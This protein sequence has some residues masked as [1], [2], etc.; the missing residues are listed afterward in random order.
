[1]GD[2]ELGPCRVYF[3]EEGSESDVGR[4][5]GGVTVSFNTDLADLMSDQFGTSPEDQVITGQGATVT[6]PLAEYT[7]KNLAFALNQTVKTTGGKQG[8]EGS[9][10][11]GT[12][13]TDKAK[14]LLIK[15]YVGGEISTDTEDWIRFPLAA[16]TGT[17]DISFD[18]STQ[19]IIEVTFTAFPNSDDV[20][21]IL[22]DETAAESG[23]SS[24][25]MSSSSASSSSASSSS[26]S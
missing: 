19:R 20:L 3:G 18:G 22:G 7:L 8:V 2:L 10:L 24:S 6:V 14:S 13:L 5:Q 25:S 17:F 11:T 26:S 15:K 16:A 1:M 9:I 21:Y 23:S 4:T 12:K